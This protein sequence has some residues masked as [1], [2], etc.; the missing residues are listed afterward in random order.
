[1]INSQDVIPLVYPA[2]EQHTL[3]D[4]VVS[5]F[6][7][8]E[9]P[10]ESIAHFGWMFRGPEMRYELKEPGGEFGSI[11]V[12]C[13]KPPCDTRARGPCQDSD[14]KN[15]KDRGCCFTLF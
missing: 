13:T 3:S 11:A 8:A 14:E 15:R 1:M 6:E 10:K 2:K 12:F 4:D 9:I 5:A 7:K